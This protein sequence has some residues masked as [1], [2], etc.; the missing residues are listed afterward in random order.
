MVVEGG[1]LGSLIRS[2]PNLAMMV[3]DGDDVSV[4]M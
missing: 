4:F 1:R 2:L 3:M